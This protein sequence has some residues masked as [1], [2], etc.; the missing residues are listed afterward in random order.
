VHKRNRSNVFENRFSRNLLCAVVLFAICLLDAVAQVESKPQEAPKPYAGI[1]DADTIWLETYSK[2]VGRRV[3]Y[4]GE[5]NKQGSADIFQDT[6]MD[7]VRHLVF[8]RAAHDRGIVVKEKDVDSILLK[9]TPDYVRRGVVDAQGKFDLPTLTAMLFNP[10][11][12]V[13]SRAPDLSANEFAEQVSELKK[14]MQGLRLQIK[15]TTTET[16]LRNILRSGFNLDTAALHD[17][18]IVDA[19]QCKADVVLIPC[20][21]RVAMPLEKDIERYHGVNQYAYTT[22]VPLRRVATLSWPMVAAPVDSALLLNNIREF[23]LLLNKAKSAVIRDSLWNSVAATTSSGVARL[24]ADSLAS[25]EFYNAVKGKKAGAAAGPIITQAGVHVLLIDSVFTLPKTKNKQYD[26]RILATQI[27]PSRETIDSILHEVTESQSMYDQG[28]PLGEVATKFG[29]TIELSR[30]F[31]ATDKLF[32]S[33]RQTEAAFST[34]VA[35]G[36]PLVETP[37]KGVVLAVVIDSIAPGSLPL[38]AVRDRVIADLQRQIGCTDTERYA[39]SVKGLIIRLP[40]GVM[41]IADKINTAEIH[42][43]VNIEV[44]GMIGDNLFDTVAATAATSSRGPGLIGPFLGDLGWYYMNIISIVHPD[45]NEFDLY[46]KLKVA[47]AVESQFEKY[48][49]KFQNDLVRDA[50]ITDNRWVYF[51]Y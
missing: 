36:C 18:F 37:E 12:V 39:K 17:Q 5:R 23:I 29:R 9:S 33:Y 45:E 34:Q 24:N 26:I 48:W 8:V 27:E 35:A 25:R 7:M 14:S 42:R 19:T 44:G 28:K 15:I 16:L 38:E 30:Y 41:I 32:G 3:A 51:R 4:L 11:S 10:D 50:S 2:E 21:T 47:E 22:A 6:W 40:E 49:A 1:V 46:V 43:D 31:S 13:K 20:N